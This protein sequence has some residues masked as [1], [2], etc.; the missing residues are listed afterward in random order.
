MKKFKTIS[1]LGQELRISA[2]IK[3]DYDDMI[4]P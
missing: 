3:A 4:V 1:T 2:Q